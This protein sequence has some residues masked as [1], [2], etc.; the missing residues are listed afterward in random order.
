MKLLLISY[1]SAETFLES[2]VIAEVAESF[3]AKTERFESG[4]FIN[5]YKILKQIGKG[6]M[7]EVYLAED[8]KLERKVALKI[9]NNFFDSEH[10]NIKRFVLEAKAASLLNHPNIV[11]IHEV[12]ESNGTHYIVSEYINGRTLND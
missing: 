11:V 12:G 6:G 10:I 3:V 8:T 9:L 2:P 7:G 1:D 4:S 5:H